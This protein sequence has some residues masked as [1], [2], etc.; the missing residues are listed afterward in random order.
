MTGRKKLFTPE[1][2][3]NIV[4]RARKEKVTDIA[5]EYGID[6]TTIYLFK[7]RHQD[8]PSDT[9]L[10]LQKLAND[11]GYGKLT[12]TLKEVLLTQ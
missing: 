4:L 3:R 10:K 6:R 9:D 8:L 12:K 5:R 2:E 1:E 11:R 7:K